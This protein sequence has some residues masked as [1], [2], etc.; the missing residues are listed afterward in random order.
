MYVMLRHFVAAEFKHGYTDDYYIDQINKL[1]KLIDQWTKRGHY[2]NLDLIRDYFLDV[3][4]IKETKA[5]LDLLSNKSHESISAGLGIQFI[6][7]QAENNEQKK[8]AK[9]L[10]KRLWQV[11]KILEHFNDT[12]ANI[13]GYKDIVRSLDCFEKAY[14][15]LWPTGKPIPLP[16]MSWE[17]YD[18][19]RDSGGV[20]GKVAAIEERLR[21]KSSVRQRS[22][23]QIVNTDDSK[24]SLLQHQV[25]YLENLLRD[26]LSKK[27]R[28]LQP[29]EG[30]KNDGSFHLEASD[31]GSSRTNAFDTIIEAKIALGRHIENYLRRL[32]ISGSETLPIDKYIVWGRVW[33]RSNN[34]AYPEKRLCFTRRGQR[35]SKIEI[36]S[37]VPKYIVSTNEL[38]D[39]RNYKMSTRPTI[40]IREITR[41]T[42]IHSGKNSSINISDRTGLS[43]ERETRAQ[44]RQREKRQ[45][46]K[47]IEQKKRQ[48]S[49]LKHKRKF[50]LDTINM[51]LNRK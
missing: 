10:R 32:G 3:A 43:N 46:F 21:G 25:L 16:K 14:K 7:G 35:I 8:K 17:E 38:F 9:L 44:L 45:R 49:L 20:K 40:K 18:F 36:K 24:L 26:L 47:K 29:A 34:S 11:R 23:S 28:G 31:I 42:T 33:V 5:W 30:L 1:L 51:I 19:K 15:K 48:L 50:L 6:L 41:P 4:A 37:D 27:D 39:T 13:N 22:H 12:P 2:D